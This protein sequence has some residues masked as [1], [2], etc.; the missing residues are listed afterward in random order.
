MN[1]KNGLWFKK[2]NKT[3]NLSSIGYEKT[4]WFHETEVLSTQSIYLYMYNNIRYLDIK[5][6]LKGC[7]NLF[8]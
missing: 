2:E 6:F 7:K 1:N 8:M 4:A 3:P 5:L